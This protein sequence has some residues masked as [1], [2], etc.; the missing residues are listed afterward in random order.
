[1]LII[2]GVCD[3]MWESVRQVTVP[4]VNIIDVVA[5]KNHRVCFLPPSVIAAT[6]E[7]VLFNVKYSSKSVRVDSCSGGF[8]S[9]L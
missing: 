6:D 5:K 1:M 9:V 4:G 8:L 2:P 3:N 7:C